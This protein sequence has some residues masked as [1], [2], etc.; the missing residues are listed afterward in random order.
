VKNPLNLNLIIEHLKVFAFCPTCQTTAEKLIVRITNYQVEKREN[1]RITVAKLRENHKKSVRITEATCENHTVRIT[2]KCE[3]HKSAET[4]TNAET[5]GSVGYSAGEKNVRITGGKGGFGGDCLLNTS[6]NKNNVTVDDVKRVTEKKEKI[7]KKE[8]SENVRITLIEYSDD[9]EKAWKI[10]PKKTEKEKSFEIWEQYKK[11]GILPNLEFMLEALKVS[12]EEFGWDNVEE[13]R[14]IQSF[15]RWLH[16]KEWR[17]VE[18]RVNLR[19]ERR[20]ATFAAQTTQPAM[21]AQ[22]QVEPPFTPQIPASVEL[23]SWDEW[24]K[25]KIG[26]QMRIAT[27]KQ[28]GVF[29]IKA[30]IEQRRKV[31]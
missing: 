5:I 13:K 12:S 27:E 17:S 4:P 19:I 2:K 3:N 23:P 29:E 16:N 7:N 10:F 31:V 14:F 15:R 30:A 22:K 11:A 21:R 28:L 8:K 25:M 1:H 9:F 24:Q 18:E 26:D 6:N 20:R